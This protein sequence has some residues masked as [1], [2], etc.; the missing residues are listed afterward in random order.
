MLPEIFREQLISLAIQ[1]NVIKESLGDFSFSLD[2]HHLHYHAVH[3]S[4]TG[5]QLAAQL[6]SAANSALRSAWRR[7]GQVGSDIV[8]STLF[9]FSLLM[10]LC[11]IH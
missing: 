3:Q 1:M 8:D 9:L 6:H 2:T 10:Q 5:K 11:K 7:Q 4:F